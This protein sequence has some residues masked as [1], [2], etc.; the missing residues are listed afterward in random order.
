PR[1]CNSDRASA[2]A[3]STLPIRP[4]RR[5]PGRAILACPPRARFSLSTPPRANPMVYLDDPGAPQRPAGRRRPSLDRG[6]ARMAAMRAARVL[7]LVHSPRLAGLSP[8]DIAGVV[9]RRPIAAGNVDV[10]PFNA[11][12]DADAAR[13][14]LPQPKAFSPPL[15]FDVYAQLRQAKW[16]YRI[17]AIEYE[18]EDLAYVRQALLVAGEIAAMTDGIIVDPI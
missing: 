7:Y 16:V 6:A 12:A 11:E 18:P 2:P 3:P 17:E 14:L 4:A 8:G 10:Q 9:A 13:E 15:P 1:L 5:E